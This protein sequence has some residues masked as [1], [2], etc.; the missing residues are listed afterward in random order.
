MGKQ[1]HCRLIDGPYNAPDVQIGDSLECAIGGEC[2]VV[3][4]SAGRIPWPMRKARGYG[5]VAYIL[6]GDLERAVRIESNIA[7]AHWWGAQR[8]TISKWR[9]ALGVGRYTPGTRRVQCLLGHENLGPEAHALGQAAARQPEVMARMVATRRLKTNKTHKPW[10]PAE[11]ALLGTQIDQEVG[12]QLGRAKAQVAARRNLLKIAPLDRR[13]SI[14][15]APQPD[16]VTI[17]PAKLYARRTHLRLAQSAIASRSGVHNSSYSKI[18]SGFRCRIRQKT[19]EKIAR[20][21]ECPPADLL[22]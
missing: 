6:C 12:T 11:D 1:E 9:G 16:V 20:A 2:I 13:R 3:G 15:Y 18:E 10:T 17:A 22:E 4:W 21:L 8:T 14:M 19:L 7:I 5:R